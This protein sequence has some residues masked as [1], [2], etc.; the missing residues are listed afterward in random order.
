MGTHW[1]YD[2]K[3][4]AETVGTANPEF[5]DPPSPQ[6][7]N[8]EEYPG[9]YQDGMLSPYGEQLLFVTD[10]IASTSVNCDPLF[11]K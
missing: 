10:H 3:K 8:S 6:F 4:M 5:K 9:H 2:P 7:Y 1:I 11:C